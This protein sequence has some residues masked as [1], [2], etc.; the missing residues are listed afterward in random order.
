MVARFAKCITPCGLSYHQCLR[1][2]EEQAA[3]QVKAKAEAEL[4]AQLFCSEVQSAKPMRRDGTG[5]ASVQQ[6]HRANVTTQPAAAPA[7]RDGTGGA[8]PQQ[9]KRASY[10]AEPAAAPAR[11]AGM[12]S[13]MPQQA[14]RATVAAEPAAAPTRRDGTGSAM[15]QQAQRATAATEPTAAPARRAAGERSGSACKQQVTFRLHCS[16]SVHGK[17]HSLLCLP[18]FSA[19]G[20]LS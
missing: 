5:G 2:A 7:R 4:R 6:L 1:R 3:Q 14:K 9:A 20:L 12:G 18:L 19:S 17:L 8:M 13:A 16:H 11:R 10:A 15:P